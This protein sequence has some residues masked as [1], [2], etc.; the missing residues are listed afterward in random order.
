MPAF[1]LRDQA[2]YWVWVEDSS[3][4]LICKV[5]ASEHSSSRGQDSALSCV[6]KK[7]SIDGDDA[8]RKKRKGRKIKWVSRIFTDVGMWDC[9][10]Y[11]SELVVLDLSGLG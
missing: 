6:A 10:C 5:L 7:R 11:I 8:W 2:G 9:H 3:E 1:S 4:F